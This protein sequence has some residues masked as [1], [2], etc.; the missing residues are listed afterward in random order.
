MA[1]LANQANL[2]YVPL[3]EAAAA[4]IATYIQLPDQRREQ[5]RICDP[6]AGEGRALELIGDTLGIPQAQRYGC[7]L[8]DVRAVAARARIGHMVACDTLK[9]LQASPEGFLL[10]YANPPFDTDG[11]EEGGGRLELK[12]LQRI[13]EEGD[14]LQRGGL[15]I[16]VTPQDIL[17]RLAC[18]SHLAKCYDDLR[19]YALPAEIRHFREAVVFGVARPRWRLG[20]ERR[21]EERR[22]QALLSG[23]LPILA[24]QTHPLYKLPAPIAR[25][26]PIVW[27]DATRGTTTM[28]QRE[29][30]V[31][32]GAWAA[33][34]YQAATAGMRRQRLNPR[35]PLHPGQ[36]VFRIA[37]GE[38]NGRTI[39]IGGVPHVIKGSTID[40]VI[41]WSEERT[42]ERSHVT[43]TRTVVR[44]LPIITAVALDGSGAIRQFAGSE[45]IAKLLADPAV[46]QALSEAVS[47]AAPPTYRLDLEPWLAHMLAGIIPKKAL[48]GYKA[49]VLPM[50]QHVIAAAVRAMTS[51]DAAWGRAP[52]SVVVAAEMGTGKAQP[53]DAK[54][55]TPSG[56]KLMGNIRVGDRVIG[57]QGTP[58]RVIGVFPQ[59]QKAIYQVRF[60]DGSSTECCDE[61]LWQVRSTNHRFR[62][63]PGAVMGLQDFRHNLR[64]PNGNH[65]WYIPMVQA[66]EF[67]AQPVPLD[68][69]L[70]GLLIG[71]GHLR[72]DAVYLSTADAELQHMAAALLPAGV[73]L[74][75]AGG[76]DYR[77][78]IGRHGGNN[79]AINPMRNPV[80]QALRTLRLAGK[81][82]ESKFIPPMY[83]FN[84]IANRVALLQ[85]LFDTDGSIDSRS[86]IEFSTSSEQL[87]HDVIELV[88]SLGGTATLSAR[89]P[90]YTYRG[91]RRE[92][93]R[94]YRL[95][96]A[97]P[98]EIRPFRLTRKAARY[99]HRPKY[100]PSR[101]VTEVTYVGR[102]E[103]Q[104]IAVDAPDHLYVTDDYIVTHNTVMGMLIGHALQQFL[105]GQTT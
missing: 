53:F 27:K 39:T 66:V 82:A 45:G 6:C 42:T 69:Y 98:A 44:K 52:S 40:E 70:I 28:A 84:T 78:S 101:A 68:P 65:R 50:Q 35:F 41:E 8:H 11:A 21:A 36:R 16:I 104:C 13:V 97:L 76:Y 15:M 34:A 81:R 56:W 4:L 90:K 19:A 25:K 92:G 2:G 43:E 18:I 32:G 77:F 5:I 54:L 61:H 105:T 26:K 87:S 96:I 29:V 62:K 72:K 49:G 48:P 103:A 63:Q 14:W 55:L 30:A 93:Q 3:P 60:S 71:D 22:V 94:S 64:M 7:E 59:G 58:I 20:D 10:T 24:P 83:K 89:I 51:H 57:S 74:V 75:F 99:T 9:A 17:A 86:H 88:Q 37:A 1:R 79:Q 23:D 85:G 100:P 12:F 102:K 38:I 67:S 47:E 80:L 46:S 91:Q 95:N 73:R 31:H 33:P